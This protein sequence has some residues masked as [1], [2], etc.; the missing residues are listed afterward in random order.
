MIKKYLSL[1]LILSILVLF[2]AGCCCNLSSF[3]QNSDNDD[4]NDRYDKKDD[5]HKKEEHEDKDSFVELKD[6][7]VSIYRS[8]SIISE[9]Q[10]E[11][12]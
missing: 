5:E 2:L 9:P 12:V 11:Y 6:Q 7:S 4:K 1:F 10:F 8:R 3:F